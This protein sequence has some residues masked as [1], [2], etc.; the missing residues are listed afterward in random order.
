MNQIPTILSI[1]TVLLSLLL[2]FFSTTVSVHTALLVTAVTCSLNFEFYL[3]NTTFQQVCRLYSFLKALSLSLL[4]L[5]V[6]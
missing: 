6:E 4:Q 1:M 2:L 5:E 3:V